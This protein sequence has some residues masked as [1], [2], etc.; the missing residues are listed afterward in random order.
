MAYRAMLAQSMALLQKVISGAQLLEYEQTMV[1][2]F[3]KAIT[4]FLK[5][6]IKS[7]SLHVQVLFNY[8]YISLLYIISIHSIHS[9]LNF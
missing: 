5:F 1:R 3:F 9:V 8:Y 2:K 7:R 6:V 4:Y